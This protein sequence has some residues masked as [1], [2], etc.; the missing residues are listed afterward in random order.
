MVLYVLRRLA[1]GVVLALLATLIT[2]LLLASSE[3]GVVRNRLGTGATPDAVAAAKASMGFDRP[4]LVQ[5][6]D[7]LGHVAR[8]DFG[9]SYG[10]SEP[11]VSAVTHRLGVTLSIVLVSMLV[12]AVV[13]VA[14][15]VFA[16]SRGGALDRLAQGASLIGNLVPNLLFAIALVYVLAIKLHWLPATGYTPLG[17]SPSRWL[18]SIVIPVIALAIGGAA[19]LTAQV[20]GSMI[21]EL[22]KDYVRTLRT[23]GVSGRSIVLRHALRNAA[24]PAL[25]V[26][27]LQFVA[28]LGGALIIEQLFALPGFGTLTFQASQ[29]GDIPV[30]LGVTVFG[31]LLVVGV[32]LLTDIVNGWLNPKARLQ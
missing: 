23:R 3:E 16:A 18:A 26:L 7:W 24:S 10:S 28:M 14:L 8:G 22:R 1:A 2:F 21:D 29:Q 20:R 19:P 25:T 13:S 30:V 17:E 12:S 6:L 11:V 31:V 27:S 9:V 15:G 4:V 5:Y 32:N